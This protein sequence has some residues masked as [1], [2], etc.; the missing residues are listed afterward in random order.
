M[1]GPVSR[2]RGEIKGIPMKNRLKRC[3]CSVFLIVFFS[4]AAAFAQETAALPDDQVKERLSF[5]EKALRAAQPRAKTWWYGWIAGYSAG[6]I[7][8]GALAKAHWND[9]KLIESF[10]GP[11]QVRDRD[12]AE[13]M[14]VGGV[15]CALGAGGLLISPFVPAYGPNQLR[16]MPEATLEER[17]LKL[18]KAEELLRRCARREKDG[19]GWVT[20][21]LNLGVNAAAGIVTVAAFDRPWSDGALTF[22]IGEAV[23]LLTIYT[24]PRQ[25]IRDLN[26][27]EVKYLGRHGAYIMEPPD[28]KL[29]FS[30]YPG[31]F[32]VAMRF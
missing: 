9:T 30:V 26:N 3:S 7:V 15:T 10:S 6:A 24:Q 5:V 2:L 14:L 12:F 27:Y 18:Q 32:S 28:R 21:L 31:G 8:Q 13:D 11:L 17:R 25:A 1:S 22:A 20:Q 4:L 19:R 29:V 23:S 16:L